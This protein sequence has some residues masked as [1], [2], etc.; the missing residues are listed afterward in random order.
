MLHE[1]DTLFTLRLYTAW[2]QKMTLFC[3]ILDEHDTPL[4]TQVNKWF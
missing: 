2:L 1:F 4:V 3:E